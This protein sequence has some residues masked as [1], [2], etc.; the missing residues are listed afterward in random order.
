MYSGWKWSFPQ[1]LRERR[2]GEVRAAFRQTL[3]NIPLAPGGGGGGGGKTRCYILFIS[4]LLL[5]V[6]EDGTTM[7][8]CHFVYTTKRRPSKITIKLSYS[9]CKGDTEN[10]NK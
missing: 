2:S 10:T 1:G 4:I 3:K 8:N 7:F 6:V 9:M 5:A